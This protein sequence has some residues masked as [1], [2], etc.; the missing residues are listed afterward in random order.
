MRFQGM[1]DN[2]LGQGHIA[3]EKLTENS[4]KYRPKVINREADIDRPFMKLLNTWQ[5]IMAMSKMKL[6]NMLF[7]RL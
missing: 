4:Q 3:Q 1:C 6:M 7:Q 2:K 5:L